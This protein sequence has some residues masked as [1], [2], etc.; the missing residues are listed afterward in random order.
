MIKNLSE[1]N[2]RRVV[3]T[4]LGVVSSIGIGWQDFWKNLLA[5]KSGISKITSFDTSQYDRHYG[6]EVKNF[7]PYQFI[8]KRK[9][10][11]MGRASQMAIAAAKLALEDAGL[12]KGALIGQNVGVCVGTT[13]GEPIILEILNR[14]YIQTKHKEVP[15]E[16]IPFYPASILG[17]NLANFFKVKSNNLVFATACSAGN[18]SI[19][20]SFDLIKSGKATMMLAGGVDALTE[21]V[22]TGFC[23]LLAMAPEKCQPFDKNRKGMIL[24]EGADILVVESLESA[25]KRKAFI[26]AEIL[27]YGLSCDA[28]HMTT[29][30]SDQV[31]KAI[32]KALKSA[33][34]SCNQIDYI[35]AHGTGTVEN[36]R[37]E[38]RAINNVFSQEKRPVPVSSI[39]SMLG[40]SLGAA[41]A[42]EA[43]TCC[44]AIKD[45]KM[46]PTIGFKTK[47]PDCDIDCVPNK[48]R[49]G[50]INI[51][52]NNSQAFG[53]NNACLVV[54]KF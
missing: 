33:K 16:F 51:V 18:Y 46:P 12:N 23:R 9:A 7:N 43:I 13:M 48:F 26:Y 2:D 54:R 45:Q 3:V 29:A 36:D 44:L 25:K 15:K 52:L 40:H 50:K 47:D 24:G 53:G 34:I 28:Q 11:R 8:D 4:G 21:I 39:K 30:S 17:I 1:N 31:S 49:K 27:G 37:I 35:S 6:G 20:Y 32:N 22:F 5:G 38:C 14:S 10:D 42:I 41:A 19:G